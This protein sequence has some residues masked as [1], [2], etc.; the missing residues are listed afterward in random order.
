MVHHFDISELD[1]LYQDGE[2]LSIVIQGSWLS[3]NIQDSALICRHWRQMFPKAEII[4]SVST[5]DFIDFSL[6]TD[7][8]IRLEVACEPFKID[9]TRREALKILFNAADI[10]VKAHDELPFPPIK[11]DTQGLNHVNLQIQ[12]SKA[13]LNHVSRKYTLRIRSDLCLMSKNFL[14]VYRKHALKTRASYSTFTQRILIPEIFTINPLTLYRMP[15]H[16]SDWFHFGSSED[17]KNLWKE[18]RNVSFADSIY[19]ENHPFLKDTNVLEKK[20]LTRLAVEQFIHFPYFKKKFPYLNLDHHNDTRSLNDSLYIMADNFVV[21]NLTEIDA[22]IKKYQHVVR[23]ISK[24]T[25]VEC[26]SQDI[27]DSIID[28]PALLAHAIPAQQKKRSNHR[29]FWGYDL[30]TALFRR[31]RK[32]INSVL[33]WYRNS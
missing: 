4:V 16:Y 22:Y 1:D 30:R 31:G 17:I 32:S 9:T 33:R 20:F 28:D 12:A 2:L 11:S 25:R 23:K 18:V 24:H 19:Y 13:G 29:M 5:S 8:N 3:K 7:E 26:I 27:L 15:F 14:N 21:T 6:N 10:I